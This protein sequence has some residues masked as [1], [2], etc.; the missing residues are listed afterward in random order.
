METNNSQPVPTPVTIEKIRVHALLKQ[1]AEIGDFGPEFEALE[2]DLDCLLYM[3]NDP[4]V[5]MLSD[6]ELESD[7]VYPEPPVRRLPS[8]EIPRKE[9]AVPSRLREGFL[10]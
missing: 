1:M 5:K 9:G 8:G 7:D 10:R 4:Y 2:Q 6:D 3:E